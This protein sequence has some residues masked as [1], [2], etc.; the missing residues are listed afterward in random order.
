MFKPA[1]APWKADYSRSRW[2]FLF[3]FLASGIAA[4]A[5]PR[6]LH[7]ALVSAGLAVVLFLLFLGA[8]R[9]GDRRR[10]GQ[11]TETSAVKTLTNRLPP[12]WKSESGIGHPSFGDI[13]ALLTDP[14]KAK[15]VVEIKSFHGLR[16]SSHNELVKMNGDRLT[17][18]VIKQVKAQIFYVN[19]KHAII[20]MPNARKGS[21]FQHNGVIIVSG[22]V[23][24]L[25]QLLCGLHEA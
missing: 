22:G 13:D 17:K 23:D 8:R 20:W 21:V 10:F 24:L 7:A 16:L 11:R 15:Y 5:A 9:S 14:H 6:N 4:V 19:A 1:F 25:L 3:S 2:L 12:G 18:D